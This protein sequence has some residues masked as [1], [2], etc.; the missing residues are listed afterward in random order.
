MQRLD[1]DDVGVDVVTGAVGLLFGTARTRSDRLGFVGSVV[2][3]QSLDCVLRQL[4]LIYIALREGGYTAIH[5]K[6]PRSGRGLN[7]F[8]DSGDLSSIRRSHS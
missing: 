3:R 8:P 6:R 2:A 4:P 7:R 1:G 5:G